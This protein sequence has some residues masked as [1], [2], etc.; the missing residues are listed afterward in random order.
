MIVFTAKKESKMNDD[1]WRMEQSV[2]V[3][4]R[5]SFVHATLSRFLSNLSLVHTYTHTQ[6]H[7]HDKVS[8]GFSVIFEWLLIKISN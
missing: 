7:T 8:L 4:G 2:S 1:E 3:S 6:A 5:N